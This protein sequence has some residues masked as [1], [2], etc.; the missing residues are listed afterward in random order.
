MPPQDDD[1]FPGAP[2]ALYALIVTHFKAMN[3]VS[4]A[5]VYAH[6]SANEYI[7]RT[8]WVYTLMRPSVRAL[9]SLNTDLERTSWI[10]DTV[11]Y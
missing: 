3:L 9:L 10:R 11:A 7:G 1:S 5:S 2:G 6:L 8:I 4:T